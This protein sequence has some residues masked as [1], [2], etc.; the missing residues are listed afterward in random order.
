MNL[1]K[2][3]A[4]FELSSKTM[5]SGCV[6]MAVTE[7]C[8]EEE[9]EGGIEGLEKKRYRK[10]KKMALDFVVSEAKNYKIRLIYSL[11][12]N[13]AGYG[14]RPQYVKWASCPTHPPVQ[15]GWLSFGSRRIPATW[16]DLPTAVLFHSISSSKTRAVR[17]LSLS[18]TNSRAG[19]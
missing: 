16:S 13:W 11:T 3:L 8:K 18:T 15:T 19:E 7:M 5:V 1:G 14:G 10:G 9:N 2:S 4:P 12:I 6:S 17:D